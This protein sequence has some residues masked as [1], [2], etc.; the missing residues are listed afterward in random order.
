M[1][2]AG[3]SEADTA[4][5]LVLQYGQKKALQMTG[6]GK[7]K[8]KRARSR[9]E[10]RYWAAVACEIELLSSVPDLASQADSLSA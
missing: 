2:I 4:R 7:M 3:K 10:Y 6:T 5:R 9:R 8:A 1:T